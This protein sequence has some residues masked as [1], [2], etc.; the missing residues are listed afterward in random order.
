[1][2]TSH[3]KRPL[4]AFVGS[5]TLAPIITK[6]DVLMG[7]DCTKDCPGAQ[8]GVRKMPEA[9]YISVDARLFKVSRPDI[10]MPGARRGIRLHYTVQPKMTKFVQLNDAM[11]KARRQGKKALAAKILK[12]LLTMV[13]TKGM[14]LHMQYPQA[15]PMGNSHRKTKLNPNRRNGA[16]YRKNPTKRRHKYPTTQRSAGVC[17]YIPFQQ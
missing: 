6:N 8:A 7:T 15:F 2:A 17:T 16:S 11:H 10:K 5:L 1:M 14:K 4:S 12:V 3:A 9:R 13:G